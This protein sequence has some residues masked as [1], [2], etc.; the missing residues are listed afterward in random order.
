MLN[1]VENASGNGNG[2]SSEDLGISLTGLLNTG[3]DY[4]AI[5]VEVN[6]ELINAER[7][8][9]WILGEIETAR[10]KLGEFKRSGRIVAE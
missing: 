2:S 7:K 4:S 10:D 5:K 9:S 8:L 1:L 3:M 6:K